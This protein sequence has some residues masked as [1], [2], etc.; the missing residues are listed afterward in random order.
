MLELMLSAL[1][2]VAS[3]VIFSLDHI[4]SNRKTSLF[5]AFV[6]RIL[7]ILVCHKI[8]ES[9]LNMNSANAEETVWR[10]TNKGQVVINKSEQSTDNKRHDIAVIINRTFCSFYLIWSA[11]I[12]GL[13]LRPLIII[14]AHDH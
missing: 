8:K 4:Q 2:V 10:P 3:I 9:N 6:L 1:N 13:Y 5:F 7:G 12:V 11:I 14:W